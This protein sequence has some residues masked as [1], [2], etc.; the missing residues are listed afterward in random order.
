MTTQWL[1]ANEAAEYLK[2]QT[3]TLLLWARMGRVK[4]YTLSGLARHT[5]RF[6]QEDLDAAIMASPSVAPVK[7]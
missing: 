6:R 7:G 4:G 2:I 5:W 1:T 3:R